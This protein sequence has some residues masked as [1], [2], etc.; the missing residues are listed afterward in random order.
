MGKEIYTTH[1]VAKFCHVAMTTVVNWIEAGS[2]KAFKTKGGHRRVKR[3]DLMS[4]IKEHK[5][6]ISLSQNILVVDDDESIR[7]ALKKMLEQGGY[8]VNVAANGFEAGML[9]EIVRPDLVVLDLVMAGFD[10]FWVC[11]KIRSHQFLKSTKI[12][13]LSGYPS[14]ENWANA[15]KAGANRCLSKPIDGEKLLKEINNLLVSTN[16]Q[17]N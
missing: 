12:I 7:V 4:F 16:S 17:K 10:G 15:K 11:E 6:P 13:V 3:I 14:K 8:K 2:L 1:D 9:I 5:M